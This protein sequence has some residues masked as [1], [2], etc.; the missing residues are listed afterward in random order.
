LGDIPPH[1]P[2]SIKRVA[3]AINIQD[4]MYG[5]AIMSDSPPL[6]GGRLKALYVA[7]KRLIFGMGSGHF[8]YSYQ[9]L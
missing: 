6:N 5:L 9:E 2:A 3:T 4:E 8:G 7:N 1:Y